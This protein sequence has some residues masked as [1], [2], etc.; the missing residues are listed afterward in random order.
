[1]GNLFGFFVAVKE[2]LNVL[3]LLDQYTPLRE[4]IKPLVYRFILP[5]IQSQVKI[6]QQET[7]DQIFSIIPK[8]LQGLID[9][10]TVTNL[11]M[12]TD[13]AVQSIAQNLSS[14]LTDN[15]MRILAFFL[16]YLAVILIIKVIASIILAPFGFLGRSVNHGGGFFFGALSVFVGIAVFVGLI[17]IVMPIFNQSGPLLLLQ[18]SWFYPYLVQTF[19][20]LKTIFQLELTQGLVSPISF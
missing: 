2:Y 10:G 9:S 1:M 5:S 19:E 18:G 12:Y 7:L 15:L 6:N 11:Q 14:V 17:S 20:G 16:T 4:W 13:N 3:N 8:K